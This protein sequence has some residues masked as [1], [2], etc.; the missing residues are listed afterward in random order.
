M[1][2][3]SPEL[4]TYAFLMCIGFGFIL[5]FFYDLVRFLRKAFFNF[6]IA[7]VVQDISY[8]VVSTFLVYCFLLCV[9]DGE[10]RAYTIFGLMLGFVIYYF[11]FGSMVV[12]F[13]D[14]IALIIRKILNPFKKFARNI[15]KKFKK[16]LKK[17]KNKSNTT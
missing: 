6:K 5:G 14:K 8:C 3:P 2:L 4:Q 11:T 9:N 17:N 1:Y 7:L 13:F 16:Y 12:G 15:A 10:V